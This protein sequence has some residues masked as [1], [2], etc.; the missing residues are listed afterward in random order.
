MLSKVVNKSNNEEFPKYMQNS[1]EIKNFWTRKQV[2]NG[3]STAESNVQRKRGIQPYL[4]HIYAL[5]RRIWESWDINDG[6]FYQ[7]T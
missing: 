5:Q 2:F 1:E 7:S 6:G 3:D 4:R